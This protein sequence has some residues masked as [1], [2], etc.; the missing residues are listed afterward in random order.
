MKTPLII[1][2]AALIAVGCNKDQQAAAD[3]SADKDTI[4][5]S[6]REAKSEVDKEAKAQK[7]V[8]DAEAK[9]AR[10]TIDAEKA[11]A[12]AATT[13]AQGKVD[14]AAQNIREAAGSAEA[15][16]QREV[17]A[18]TSAPVPQTDTRATTEK[19]GDADQKLADQVRS[20]ISGGPAGAAANADAAKNIEVSASGGV[21][22]LKGTVKTE[23]EKTQAESQAKSV[24]GVTKVE[25]QLQVKAD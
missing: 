10:A 3:R 22:T 24:A 15:K 11:R 4:Q 8:L 25:N 21:V 2:A 12:K 20:A 9:A 16:A 19:A 6:V 5:K 1:A 14:A 7:E 13:D 17:G 18:A 23:A